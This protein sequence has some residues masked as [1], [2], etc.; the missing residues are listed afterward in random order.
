MYFY[1]TTIPR[2]ASGRVDT[3]D[4][5]KGWA[6][7]FMLIAHSYDLWIYTDHYLTV[8]YHICAGMA[9]VLFFSVTGATID[10]QIR[11][12]R[13]FTLLS[14]YTVFFLLAFINMAKEGPHYLYFS[15]YN[16]FN[17]IAISGIITAIILKK[18]LNRW[19]LFF[20]PFLL[21]FA[22]LKL[23]LGDVFP[24]QIRPLFIY[25]GFG[26][27]PWLSFFLIGSSLYSMDRKQMILFSVAFLLLFVVASVLKRPRLDFD[28]K[29]TMT[30]TYYFI[31]MSLLGGI[32][33]VR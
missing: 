24:S 20:V 3:I 29:T 4:Q 5:L 33:D 9:P 1:S 10:L 18:E 17:T 27:L 6:C 2:T 28:S 15:P 31:A 26:I 16:I 13:L 14:F 21:H 23:H 7:I 32:I 30:V 8:I 19:W 22:V 25:P 11:K 12:R